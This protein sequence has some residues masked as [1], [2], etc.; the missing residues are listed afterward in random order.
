VARAFATYALL[1]SIA[2][3]A[4]P[5]HAEAQ[6]QRGSRAPLPVPLL[7]AEEAWSTKLPSAPAAGG[8]LDESAV[9]IP[10]ES[11]QLVALDRE[12]G[13]PRWSSAVDSRWPPIVHSG[14]VYASGLDR[15]QAV[16]ASNGASLWSSALEAAAVA[17]LSFGG[18]L[19]LAITAPGD[20]RALQ[21]S[22]GRVRWMRSLGGDPASST[23]MSADESRVCVTRATRVSCYA[24]ADGT[25]QWERELTG[26]L[27]VPV[28]SDDRVFVGSTDNSFYAMS[29]DTGRL[30]WR[31]RTGGDVIGAALDEHLVYVAS[32]DHVLRALRRGSGNQVWKR[33]LVTRTLA[34]PSAM[35][36][37]VVVN[38]H[39]PTLSSFNSVTGEPTGSFKAPGD[40]VGAPILDPQP[41]PF[42]VSMVAVTADGRAIGFRSSG[43]MFREPAAAPLQALPGRL[44]VREPLSLEG[45]R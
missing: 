30:A 16:Q 8:G 37:I 3:G 32:L 5:Y 21:A 26:T 39:A 9:Y 19:I 28:V 17:P 15:I 29:A 36:G 25:P 13:D 34:P 27:S 2:L 6:Q 35:G 4:C 33:E 22:D 11:R 42:R 20:L 41:K 44:L 14:V 31:W 23:A 43:L 10:L 45:L 38:G 24:I 40:A 1:L 12:T 7:P 18:D